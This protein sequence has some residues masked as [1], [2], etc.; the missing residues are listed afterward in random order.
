MNKSSIAF[1]KQIR[2]TRFTTVISKIIIYFVLCIWAFTTVYTLFWVVNNS[3]KDKTV[4]LTDSFS[5]AVK[6]ILD[7]YET[8]FNKLNIGRAYLNSFIISGS[9]VVLVMVF[10]GLTAYAMTR[11][12]FRLK[13]TLYLMFAG[14]LLFPAFSTIVPIFRMVLQLNLV[15]HPLGVII[16]QTA[17]NLSFAIIV[18][19]GFMSN[20]PLELEEAAFMEGCNVFDIFFRIILPISKPAFATV[21]IF[22]FLWS[23]NDLFMQMVILRK[24]ETYPICTLL[25]EI[26]SQFGTDFGLMASAVT[27]VVLPVLI[28]YLFLQKNIVKGLTAGAIKG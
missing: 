21:A 23:Y 2:K 17:S 22:T 20:L 1:E 14:S 15:S 25:N 26:S 27:I 9:T 8:A 11:Y 28:V 24:R 5:L 10:S 3:F 4:I 13:N 18:L 7:N 12:T 16:P 19:M 6:P